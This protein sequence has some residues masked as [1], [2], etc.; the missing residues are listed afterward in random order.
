MLDYPLVL[1]IKMAAIAAIFFI[2]RKQK[3]PALPGF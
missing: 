2:F 3:N 1:D